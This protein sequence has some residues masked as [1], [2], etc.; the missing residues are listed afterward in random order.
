MDH[1]KSEKPVAAI[2]PFGDG[3]LVDVYLQVKRDV[4]AAKGQF[5][6]RLP[7]QRAFCPGD[8]YVYFALLKGTCQVQV[9]L[10]LKVIVICL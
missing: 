6:T 3:E 5:K 2:S 8:E 4:A 7:R 9:L 1:K 10:G